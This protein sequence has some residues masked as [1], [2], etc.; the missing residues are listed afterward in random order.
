MHCVLSEPG[1]AEQALELGWP[2]L[3]L[4]GVGPKSPWDCVDRMGAAY[5]AGPM[6]SICASKIVYL[7]N[8]TLWI[9]Q[10]A[11]GA[12]WPWEISLGQPDDLH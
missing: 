10:Q 11:D 7:G 6:M 8:Q 12:V 5:R 1:G 3:E 4:F 9:A 2:E